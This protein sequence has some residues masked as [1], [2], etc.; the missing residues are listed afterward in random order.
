MPFQRVKFFCPKI[1]SCKFFDKFQVWVA[2]TNNR[3]TLSPIGERG[4]T[5]PDRS[6]PELRVVLGILRLI[7]RSQLYF[8]LPYITASAVLYFTLYYSLSCTL[9]GL[10]NGLSAIALACTLLENFLLHTGWVASNNP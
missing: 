4:T 5:I 2:G 3:K 9:L 10:I 1:W 7:L 6:V 8:T